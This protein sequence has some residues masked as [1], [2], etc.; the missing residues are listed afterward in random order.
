MIS[1]IT[2][3]LEEPYSHFNPEYHGGFLLEHAF[4]IRTLAGFKV[5]YK[6]RLIVSRVNDEE[7]KRAQMLKKSRQAAFVDDYNEALFLPLLDQHSCFFRIEWTTPVEAGK[8]YQIFRAELYQVIEDEDGFVV[9]GFLDT[10]V[11]AELMKI[12]FAQNGCTAMIGYFDRNN[13]SEDL[14]KENYAMLTEEQK[15][16]ILADERFG[17]YEELLAVGALRRQLDFFGTSMQQH[18]AD[19]FTIETERAGRAL[20]IKWSFKESATSGYYLWGFKD[21]GGFF[22]DPWDET[23]N[24]PRVI[25]SYRDGETTELLDEGEAYFYTFF[26]QPFNES[27]RSKRR[28]S[29][30]FQI[31]VETK[32]ER[33]AI[34]ATLRRLEQKKTVVDP[35]KE[36]ISRALKELGLYVELDTALETT[37]KAW[38]KKISN[39]D[40]Y[41]AEQKAEKIDR[42]RD[43]MA[44]LRSKYEP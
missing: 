36:H 19:M 2:R 30:R 17:A 15:A 10:R 39:N 35:D 6:L 16:T 5:E 13:F 14:I 32:K 44:T 38:E 40:A 31:T 3:R 27:E 26:L 42:L 24:G 43:A 1:P 7:F 9:D 23:N 29:L 18:E 8:I 34:E 4:R 33:E 11:R 37:T 12:P 41:S 28:S 22:K 25:D 21:R 20:K